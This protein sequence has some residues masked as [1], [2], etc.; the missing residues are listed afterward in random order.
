MLD[1]IPF[2][3]LIFSTDPTV[4]MSG[5]VVQ[6]L[7]LPFGRFFEWA[8]PTTRFNT[9][10]YVWTLNPGPFDAKEHTVITVMAKVVELGA[11]AIEVVTD[12]LF[13]VE[14]YRN[15]SPVFLS[16]TFIINY[17]LSFASHRRRYSH[18]LMVWT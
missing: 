16:A 1:R 12:G 13:D 11:Y 2:R 9:F 7:S 18:I 5:V 4:F 17:C 3:L 10:G 15:Y 14:K 6:L 8:L